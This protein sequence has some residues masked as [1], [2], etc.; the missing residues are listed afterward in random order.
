LAKQKLDKIAATTT[1]TKKKKK[2]RKGA[3][4]EQLQEK[5]RRLGFLFSWGKN[6][7]LGLKLGSHFLFIIDSLKTLK[8][9][10]VNVSSS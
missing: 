6:E 3:L 10:T 9:C 1:K 2:R 8:V 4:R 7:K 5:Q